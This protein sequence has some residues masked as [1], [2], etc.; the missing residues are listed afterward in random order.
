MAGFVAIDFWRTAGMRG[1]LRHMPLCVSHPSTIRVED[2]VP[3][4]LVDFSPSGR[5]TNQSGLRYHPDQRW[6]YYSEM[7]PDEVLAFKQAEYW[8]DT[9]EPR[10]TCFH[11]A[12][13]LPNSAPDV[14]VRQS[15]E[16]RVLVFCLRP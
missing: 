4:G 13:E 7:G 2:V 15:S 5:P 6:Y 1:P 16:Q 8:K 10:S 12:F 11:S 14:E 9:P 3:L